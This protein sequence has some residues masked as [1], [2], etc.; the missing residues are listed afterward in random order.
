MVFAIKAVN[1]A[2]DEGEKAPRFDIVYPYRG[3]TIATTKNKPDITV[4]YN[5]AIQRLIEVKSRCPLL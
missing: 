2:A 5:D 4:A 3:R 1:V